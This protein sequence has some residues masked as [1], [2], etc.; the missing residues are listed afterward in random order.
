M[1]MCGACGPRQATPPPPAERDP[2]DVVPAAADGGAAP[3]EA[4]P[5]E[6]VDAGAAPSI[7]GVWMERVEVDWPV[8]RTKAQFHG[9]GGGVAESAAFAISGDGSTPAGWADPKDGMRAPVRWRDGV[10]EPLDVPDAVA[11]SDGSAHALSFDGRVVA[12]TVTVGGVTRGVLW[13]EGDPARVL[14]SP[15]GIEVDA[16]VGLSRDGTIAIGCG[17]PRGE[18]EVPLRWTGDYV[19]ELEGPRPFNVGPHPVTTDGKIVVGVGDGAAARLDGKTVIKK[20]VGSF[21]YSIT[22]DGKAIVGMFRGEAVMWRGRSVTVFGRLP[23]HT[24]CLA[25][26]VSADGGRVVGT[27]TRADEGS[28]GWVWDARGKMRPVAEA[29]AAAKVRT[30]GWS[31]DYALD[32]CSYGVTIVG[33]GKSPASEGDGEAWMAILPR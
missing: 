15:A 24:R 25:R 28:T 9:L 14:T 13:R 29:L 16:V 10:M 5:V 30:V 3:S 2:L 22:D 4:D 12:G 26:A 21:A 19:A 33:Q 1:F 32:I 20:D 23:G 11:G 17:S 31:L 7:P 6:V 8:D 18:C 27:C